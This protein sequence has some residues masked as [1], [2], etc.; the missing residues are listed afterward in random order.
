MALPDKKV[1][2]QAGYT[3]QFR[4][5]ALR[6]CHEC[7]LLAL[8]VCAPPVRSAPADVCSAPTFEAPRT[9]IPGGYGGSVAVGD[10]NGDGKPDL[11]VEQGEL[12]APV[13]ILLGKGD[14]TFEAA[15]KYGVGTNSLFVAVGDFD[16]DGKLDVAVANY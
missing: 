5:P 2:W 7:L 15:V 6:R 12:G 1:L 8:L 16:G 4:A 14:G 10:F 3:L 13:A 11:A 9:F